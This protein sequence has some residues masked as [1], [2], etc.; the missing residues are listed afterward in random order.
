MACWGLFLNLSTQAMRFEEWVSNFNEFKNNTST[1]LLMEVQTI[2]TRINPNGQVTPRKRQ[3]ID[4][5]P[6]PKHDDDNLQAA[7]YLMMNWFSRY[8][9]FTSGIYENM[10]QINK[11]VFNIW[12]RIGTPQDLDREH[13][14]LTWVAIYY[15]LRNS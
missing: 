10:D 11:A 5:D 1:Q 4:L 7:R 13:A 12:I 6:T 15:I 3:W 14:S 2:F 9:S 8:I